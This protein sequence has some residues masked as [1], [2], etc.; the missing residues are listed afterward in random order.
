ML[1]F[2]QSVS[3]VAKWSYVQFGSRAIRL[4]TGCCRMDYWV[5]IHGH[6]KKT[7]ARWSPSPDAP[8]GRVKRR[9][10]GTDRGRVGKMSGETGKLFG[11]CLFE[12]PNLIGYVCT[13]TFTDMLPRAIDAF[14]YEVTG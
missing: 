4:I 1:A 7:F 2:V 3:P 6:T 10:R 11:L 9:R 5:S 12:S 8:E 13:I 14:F